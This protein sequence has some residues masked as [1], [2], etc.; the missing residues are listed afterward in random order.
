M[1]YRRYH[2]TI[3]GQTP[4]LMHQDNLEFAK[5]LKAW[6]V[7]P[8]NK[9]ASKGN[10]GDDRTP[11]FSWIG[12]LYVR[13]GKLVI[14]S[15]NLMTM[16]RN[17][18]VK[19]PTGKGKGTF[20]AQTQSGIVVDQEAWP[21]L[22]KGREIP[23]APIEALL[24][25]PSYEAHELAAKEMGFELFAKR[26]KVGEAKHVRVR[27]RFENWSCEGTISVFDDEIT[28]EVLQTILTFAG[29][30]AGLGDWRPGSPTSPGQFGVF[31]ATVKE[32]K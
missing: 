8:A 18:G 26:A 19:T 23:F 4:L 10:R 32:I 7:D 12:Y 21:L 27:P 31:T 20:K 16:F 3:E 30:Y 1:N 2:V 9:A 22:V 17:G 6:Q 11:A 28:T 15:D 25:E 13:F 29:R 5:T 14:P 24:N